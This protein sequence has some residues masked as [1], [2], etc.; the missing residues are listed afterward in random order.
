MPWL[1]GGPL[2]GEPLAGLADRDHRGMHRPG[3]L[4]VGALWVPHHLEVEQRG[5]AKPGP[6]LDRHLVR[7]V[8]D[9]GVGGKL[10]PAC[11]AGGPSLLLAPV[12]RKSAIRAAADPADL[13]LAVGTPPGVGGVAFAQGFDV[14]RFYRADGSNL[15]ALCRGVARKEEGTQR[16][17]AAADGVSATA[18]LSKS[19]ERPG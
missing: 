17:I 5:G 18:T 15:R 6:V 1:G 4:G 2:C 10:A 14:S 7:A 12:D 8:V 13:Y 11:E 3:D 9:R 16:A 19:T